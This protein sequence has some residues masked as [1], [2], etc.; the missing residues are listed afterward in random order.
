[1]VLCAA[2]EQHTYTCAGSHVHPGGGGPSGSAM[3]S[4]EQTTWQDYGLSW[5]QVSG[6]QDNA[7]DAAKQWPDNDQW[8]GGWQTN[9]DGHGGWQW[10]H[11]SEVS[12]REVD[13][14]KACN[15]C[16]YMCYVQKSSWRRTHKCAG[17]QRPGCEAYRGKT[18]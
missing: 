11:S 13:G 5:P 2:T 14:Y 8:Q 7:N 17:C 15:M 16:G 1:M 18:G 3:S 4:D 6:W 12:A 10:T 9:D